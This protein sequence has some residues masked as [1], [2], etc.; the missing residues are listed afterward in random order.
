MITNWSPTQDKQ[1]I[2]PLPDPV[3]QGEGVLDVHVGDL[4]Q[5][6]TANSTLT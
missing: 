1:P 4:L 5:G 2:L 6:Q 3:A